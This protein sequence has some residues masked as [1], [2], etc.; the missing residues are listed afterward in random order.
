[1]N[2]KKIAFGDKLENNGLASFSQSHNLQQFSQWYGKVFY[3][4]L[5]HK[6][7][8]IM[9]LLLI[10][11]YP[12]P[13]IFTPLEVSH[14]RRLPHLWCGLLTGFTAYGA[15]NEFLALELLQPATC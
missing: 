13:F 2:F 1:M 9:V 5:Y 3:T 7:R 10:L 8:C 4:F 15:T 11:M 14:Q 12:I 6:I